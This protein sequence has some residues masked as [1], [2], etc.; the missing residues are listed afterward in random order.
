MVMVREN[1][2]WWIFTNTVG[3]VLC[4]VTIILWGLLSPVGH[5]HVTVVLLMLLFLLFPFLVRLCWPMLSELTFLTPTQLLLTI[6]SIVGCLVSLFACIV[7]GRPFWMLLPAI[8]C[9]VFTSLGIRHQYRRHILFQRKLLHICAE[10]GYDLRASAQRCPECG[11]PIPEDYRFRLVRD[12]TA[13]ML[14][15]ANRPPVSGSHGNY[16][17]ASNG[18][19][20]SGGTHSSQTLLQPS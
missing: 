2:N 18:L 17:P 3:V 16:C 4:T 13:P 11:T 12:P 20:R 7:S 9:L 10:C 15:E 1:F 8:A 14:S 19:I 5:L 6:A